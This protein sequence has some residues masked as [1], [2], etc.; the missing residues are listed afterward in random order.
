MITK[1]KILGYFLMGQIFPMIAVLSDFMGG[2]ENPYWILYLAGWVVNIFGILFVGFAQLCIHL[3]H[4][5][6][7]LD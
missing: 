1:K 5:E 2:G 4:D 3:I 6:D 7:E